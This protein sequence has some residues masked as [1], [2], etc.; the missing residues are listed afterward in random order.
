MIKDDT[1]GMGADTADAMGEISIHMRGAAKARATIPIDSLVKFDTVRVAAGYAFSSSDSIGTFAAITKTA[2]DSAFIKIKW[3]NYSNS[4]TV[5]D[6]FNIY[7]YA[8]S[9]GWPNASFAPRYLRI[10]GTG[11][12]DSN[13]TPAPAYTGDTTRYGVRKAAGAKDTVWVKVCIPGLD[14]AA[15]GDSIRIVVRIRGNN[16][17]GTNDNWPNTSATPVLDSTNTASAN[18]IWHTHQ[19][20][21]TALQDTVWNYNDTQYDTVKIAVSGPKLKLYKRTRLVNGTARKPGDQIKY[22]I[23]YDNDGSSPIVD[24]TFIVEYLP[25]DVALVDTDTVA[26]GAGVGI[27]T[28]VLYNGAWL[29]HLPSKTTPAG[30]DSLL[31]VR[32]VKF[33]IAPGIA[34]QAGDNTSMLRADDSTGTDAGWIKYRVQ[35][36]NVAVATSVFSGLYDGA[37][38]NAAP[39]LSFQ[40]N[41]VFGGVPP[42]SLRKATDTVVVD[43]GFAFSSIKLLAISDRTTKAQ[44]SVFLRYYVQNDGN[45]PD[46]LDIKAWLIDTSFIP[47]Y[48]NVMDRDSFVAR[49]DVNADI[50]TFQCGIQLTPTALDS[51]I[52]KVRTPLSDS[53]MDQDT[54]KVVLRIRNRHRLGTNDNWPDTSNY[55]V[56]DTSN[57]Y[58]QTHNGVVGDTLWDYGD[59]QWDT[60]KI[61]IGGP[62][63]RTRTTVA[64]IDGTRKPG[65]RLLYTMLYDNDGS[66]PTADTGFY[67]AYLPIGSA[68]LDTMQTTAGNGAVIK[69]SVLYNGSWLNHI[70]DKTTASGSDSLQRVMALRFA[71]PPGINPQ[72]GT[73]ADSAMSLVADDS[74]GTDAGMIK[75]RVRIR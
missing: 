38:A 47:N 33:A 14:S 37:P 72:A 74:T 43:T 59:T 61:T 21:G 50:D 64:T 75:F 18:A 3:Q 39:E 65:D 34:A 68:L 60:V 24:T 46:S 36:K 16:G 58:I 27:K 66:A 57:I 49:T 17:T 5:P 30:M 63:I 41:S 56:F 31:R 67:V 32:A 9:T 22:T 73:V 1:T 54:M 28:Y 4:K 71:V 8:D 40:I 7:A 62:I 6:S 13:A 11:G 29:N 25:T 52:I 19:A 45:W 26:S 51:F 55:T 44:D 70:P 69:T 10:Q 20:Q 48:F 12:A 35:L 42:E 23:Y 53:A 15:D 2:K